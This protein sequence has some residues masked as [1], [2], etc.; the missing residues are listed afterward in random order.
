MQNTL[1]LEA[2]GKLDTTPVTAGIGVSMGNRLCVIDRITEERY[3]ID[4]GA[5]ISVLAARGKR[6]LDRT[7]GYKLYAAN[8]TPINT[9][10]EKSTVLNL[11]LR[12]SFRWS[13]VIADVKMSILGADF[14]NHYKL[15]VDVH[16]KKLIDRTTSLSINTFSVTTDQQSLYTLAKEHPYYEILKDFPNVLRPLS[17]KEPSKHNV[18]HHIETTGQPLFSRA[19]PL[20]PDKYQAAKEEFSKLVELGICQPSK[21]PWANPLQIVKKK[22][23]TM[24]ICG[25]YRRLNSVTLPDR[26]P[27]PRIQDFTYKLHGMR[28]FSKLDLKSAYYWIPVENPEKTAIIT[29]FGLFEF[30]CMPFGLR[31]ASQT[32]QRF[33]HEVLRDVEGCFSYVDDI[34]LYSQ[35]EESHKQVLKQVLQRLDKYGL[36]VNINKCEFAQSEIEFLGYTVTSE[37]ISPTKEHIEVISNYKKP[38]N[39]QELRRFLGMLNFYRESLPQQAQF[40]H[41]LNK[42]LHNSKKNDKTIIAWT[43]EAE[44]AFENCRQSILQAT[45]LS[46]PVPNASLCI[47]SDASDHSTG[48]V[49][50]QRVKN[51]LMPL[52]F[53]SK[54]M[55]ETQ[56]RYSTYDRE[57]LA[58][59]LSVKHFRRL[60]EG[61]D[62]VII[63]TDH[64]PLT[65]ALTKVPSDTDTFRRE[66]QLN[67]ISQFCSKIEYL[68]G[69]KNTVADWLSRIEE[70]NCPTTIDFQQLGNHQNQ[71]EELKQLRSKPNLKFGQITLPDIPIPITCEM[72]TSNPRPFLPKKYRYAVFEGQ[73]NICHAGTRTT[74][75]QIT[76]KYFWPGMNKDVGMWTKNCITCQKAKVHRHTKPPAGTFPDSARFDHVH[77]DLIGPLLLSNDYRYCV[78]MIDRFTQWPEAVPISDITAQTVA[79]I[80]YEHWIV[81]F[82]CPIRITTDQGRQF[83][84]DLFNCLLKKFGI[85]KIRTTAY[86]PKSNGKIE[87]V[88]RT[89]KAAL[90]AREAS[91]N[92]SQELPTVLFG[93]RTTLRKESNLSPC[94][95][96]Y[97]TQLRIPS[98]FF[99]PSKS[100]IEDAE[101]V[102]SL[103]NTMNSLIPTP[104]KDSEKEIFVHKDLKT[105]THVFVRTDLVRKPLTPPYQGPYEILQKSEKFY[106]I[107]LPN[108][109]AY[110]SL[111]RLKPAY[112]L[113]ED[114]IANTNVSKQDNNF[115]TRSGRISKRTVRYQGET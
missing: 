14:L 108:R 99:V 56:K 34:L 83:E 69:Q 13:F 68:Q 70:I 81:R 12:R 76:S 55:S 2:L 64:K 18:V 77:I 85:Q 105:C 45:T 44:K 97:G 8:S 86:H 107:Q 7:N 32:F 52:A 35:D 19:R 39:I 72:S 89:L 93:L 9:Y 71:D 57:L 60:I 111:D 47:M 11:G 90:M 106:Q 4:T 10:G 91:H 48:G 1:Q 49:L 42:Y 41:E 84:S 51:K 80:F 54:A 109:T 22:D 15:L 94:L 113:D 6:T 112:I 28:V 27:I 65:H 74:K 75:K 61:N 110:I 62:N 17:F 73:H 25:D 67:F 36:A 59:Y 46:H 23:G 102:K 87:R 33:M 66:R 114:N 82:G 26:Y 78:T 43:P 29:P 92:W 40:Q 100:K 88:H 31:N 95:L 37:G 50:H 96:T 3:L 20:A 58:I 5:E 79:R 103:T 21:S 101:F 38:E 115:I 30:R 53:F 24:R 104:R 16:N 98:D 63:Y